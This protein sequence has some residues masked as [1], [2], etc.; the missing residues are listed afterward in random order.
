MEPIDTIAFLRCVL[1]SEGYY[2]AVIFDVSNPKPGID[3]PRQQWCSTI[4]ELAEVLLFNDAQGKTVYHAC[5]SFNTPTKR[6]HANARAARSL[7]LDVDAGEGKPYADATEAA[8]AVLDFCRSSGLDNPVFVGSGLGL[9]VYWPL[10]ADLDPQT[11]KQY[12]LGF[13]SL[14]TQQGLKADPAR[15]SDISSILRTPGTHHRKE[16]ERL[17]QSGP[18]VCPSNID[19]FRSIARLERPAAQRIHA[20]RESIIS[21]IL[22]NTGY[23]AAYADTIA[24]ACGQIARFRNSGNM[25]EPTWY[26]CLGV[27]AFCEDGVEKAHEWSAK[28]FPSYTAQETDFKLSRARAL[29]GATTCA[30]LND[31]NP[32]VCQGCPH[33]GKINS[34]ISLGSGTSAP[35]VA[36]VQNKNSLVDD[37]PHPPSPFEWST[38]GQLRIVMENEGGDPTITLVAENPVYLDSVQTG[39]LD[40]TS[41][42]YLFKKYLPKDGWSDVVIE[43]GMLHGAAGIATMFGKG[44][45]IHEPKL[46]LKYVRHQVD[47]YHAETTLE[48]RFDQF[49]WKNENSSFLFGK[50]L[51]TSVG[52]VESIG[53]KEVS[54]RSQYLGPK[55]NGNL[56]AW[57]EA[58]DSLFA[59]DM[60]GISAVIL[61]SFAAPLM[62]L[63]SETEGGAII[64][65]FT[66]GSGA[67]KTTALDGAASVWGMREGLNLTNE[68]TQVSKPIMLGVLGNLPVI[69]DE[70]RDK[71][72]EVIKKLVIMF[73]N[74]RDRMRGTVEG[75][76]RHTKALW[77]TVLL[78]AANTSILDQ[79]QDGGVDAPAFRVLELGVTLPAGSDKTKGDRL[80]RVLRENA[81]HAGDA[82]LR[83]LMHPEVLKWTI[84]ALEKWTTDIWKQ[85][86][87][88]DKHRFR[89]RLVGA[90][91]VA[92]ALVNKLGILHFQTDR[93]LDYLI[94]EL[95]VGE[96][97]GTVSSGPP[98]DNAINMLGEF[99]NAHISEML[100]VADRY[101]PKHHL[102]VLLKPHNK[103][104]I[105][106]E[107]ATRRV[108]IAE[109]AFKTWAIAQ[110]MSPRLTL[111][112]LKE[113]GVILNFHRNITLSAGTD[114]PGAQVLCIEA[115]ASH[116][117]MSGLVT[118][119][120][121]VGQERTADGGRS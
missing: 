42:S 65:M 43:A 10:D 18:L 38:K 63:Q 119:V 110:Q 16:G 77:Q 101:R 117:V 116:P 62:R 93:V 24:D 25:A 81:G 85:T 14:C 68:D 98:I 37:L 29:T 82:Y 13:K 108:Y 102:P 114:I 69:Y 59:A 95:G 58:A 75:T 31:V 36:E 15:T 1:P 49:G 17:V 47:Q 97:R 23:A 86:Q 11:W 35:Q 30:K 96:N 53:A 19:R 100:V 64:H 50:M 12:A 33:W 20:G 39:E 118:A 34:P 61:S 48:T 83:Y 76:I 56:E 27:V 89:V 120:Q 84:E 91:A 8:E 92:S 6:T 71:D 40:R 70:L 106:H 54:Q 66:P 3:F 2:C 5:A 7:W 9:H 72:P 78:S 26:G 28:D 67:G 4:E 74:G 80:K 46:F 88:D 73:T 22:S 109:S 94:K 51:Y 90:I 45:V 121:N 87:L 41:F 111:Q 103:L 55:P 44:V 113:N 107:I 104:T 79:L 112:A 52:P 99:I 60:A 57:T 32:G 21:R 105:R 115:D